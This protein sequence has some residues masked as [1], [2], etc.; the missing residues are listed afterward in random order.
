[1]RADADDF[2]TDQHGRGFGIGCEWQRGH[3]CEGRLLYE[4]AAGLV[5]IVHETRIELR[6]DDV[7][8]LPCLGAG[9]GL[10]LTGRPAHLDCGGAI[11][12]TQAEIERQ[13]AL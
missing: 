10:Q 9:E 12:I 4:R 3:R 5:P 13:I 1:M 8:S 6:L 7:D 11:G 2:Q